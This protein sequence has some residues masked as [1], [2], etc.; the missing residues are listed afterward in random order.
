MAT[1]TTD[2]IR[3]L[4]ERTGGGL[5]ECK[6]ALDTA[7]GNIEAALD[8]MR[9]AGQ[10]KAAKRSGRIA[11]EGMIAILV[12]QDRKSAFIM[13]VNCE[14]DFVARD[15]SFVN[16]VNSVA[17]HGQ[18][19]GI[20]NL[21]QLLALPYSVGSEKTIE[22]TRTDLV[23]KIGENIQIRRIAAMN[24]NQYIYSYLHGSRIGVLV[25][26]S[27][28]NEELGKDIAMHIA[29]SSPMY[30]REE[31]VPES[32]R[33]REKAIYLAQAMESG[34]PKEIAEKMIIGRMKKFLAEITLLGQPFVK[35]PDITVEALLKNH[36]AEVLSFI[37]F[38]VGDGIEKEVKDFAAE[39]ASII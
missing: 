1:I 14:T 12:S 35:N 28:A 30:V 9:A 20:D 36:N 3:E 32:I 17:A 39:V 7:N 24:T 4:R 31:D 33:E 15:E 5:L 26:L 25:N 27:V 21:E 23:G 6:K 11:S 34:K 37:R 38:G 10:A 29:A 16:F 19:S 13:E 18:K 2:M 22:Q 8:A